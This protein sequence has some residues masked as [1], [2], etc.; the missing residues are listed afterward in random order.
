MSS[1]DINVLF[2]ELS[3]VCKINSSKL[4]NITD[5]ETEDI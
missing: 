2:Y 1:G 4:S 3:F 5:Y